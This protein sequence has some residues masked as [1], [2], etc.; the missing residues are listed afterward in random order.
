MSRVTDESDVCTPDV[1]Q[2][3]KTE[4][5]D[6]GDIPSPVDDDRPSGGRPTDYGEPPDYDDQ[7]PMD[8]GQPDYLDIPSPGDED[9]PDGQRPTGVSPSDYGERPD[10][11]P[12]DYLDVPVPR[13]R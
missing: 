7:R 13:R 2:A 6:Y 4:P 9:S 5:P 10:G 8:A 12:P 1:H 11:E 3:T